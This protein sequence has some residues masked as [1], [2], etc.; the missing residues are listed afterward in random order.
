[1]MAQSCP[2][3]VEKSNKHIKKICTQVGSIYKAVHVSVR[4]I[5]RCVCK[6]EAM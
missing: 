4:N 3:R 5:T 2:K 1:M 6:L